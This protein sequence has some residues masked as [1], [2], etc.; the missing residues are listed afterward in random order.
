MKKT[1][2]W[3][4][5]AIFM[6]ETYAST[7]VEAYRQD[8]YV[9]AA[10]LFK[11]APK[12]DAIESYYLGR[13]YLYGYGV[14]KSNMLAS[15]YIHTAA[16]EGILPAQL[17]MAKMEL[18][19][20]ND[21]EKALGWFKRAADADDASAQ[22]YC[23]GAY[24]FGVG[25]KANADRARKYYI[26]AARDDN[27]I[28]QRTLAA[29]FL[30]SR[31]MS[32]KKLGLVWLKKAVELRDPEAEMMI[33]QMYLEG[34]M[35]TM[36]QDQ[37]KQYLE[38]AVD[39][40]Y[41]PA[42]VALGRIE[43][44][45]GRMRDAETWYRKAA[46]KGFT[47][48]QLIL[49]SLYAD[50]ENELYSAHDGFLWM[51][52]AGQ[53][54]SVKARHALAV[55]YEKGQGVEAN[56]TVAASWE[57][58]AKIAE[59]AS[60]SSDEQRMAE[61]LTN[62]KATRL[63][64]TAYRLPGILGQWKNTAAL[65]EGIYNQP[66][67][68]NRLTRQDIYRTEFRMLDPKE[69][70][71]N[72]Y[73]DALMMAQGPVVQSRLQFPQ[74]PIHISIDSNSKHKNLLQAERDGY[75]Y[76]QKISVTS[77][78]MDYVS[79]FKQLM[80]QAVLGDG[81]AQF[82]VALMYQ[83][84]IG[85]KKSTE[86]AIKFYLMAAAQDD[87]PAEYQLGLIYFQGWGVTP[88]E[89]TGI[90]FLNDAAFKGNT[91][92]QYALAR[93]YEHGYAVN[94]KEIIP[95]DHE[96]AVAMYQLSAANH[97]GMAEY[98]LAEIMVRE[99][100]VDLSDAG[101][102]DRR[103]VIKRLYEDS[104]EAGVEAA[105]LPLAFYDATDPDESKQAQAFEEAQRVAKQGSFDGA[106]LLGL[107]YDRGIATG[108]SHERAIHWYEQSAANPLSSFILGTYAAEGTG[109]RKNLEKASNYL[110]FSANKGFAPANFNLAVLKHDQG[111]TFLPYLEKSVAQGLNRAGLT[112]ADYLVSSSKSDQQLKEAHDLYER[113][114]TQGDPTAQV[115]LGYLYEQGIGVHQDY[116][117]AQSWYTRAAEQAQSRGQFLLGRLY[118][119]GWIGKNPDM[120]LAKKWYGEAGSK[121]APAAV[122]YGFI[123]ETVN[124]DYMHAFN[125]YQKAADLRDPIAYFNLGLIYEN[126]KGQAI[127]WQKAEDNYLLAAEQG[128]VKAMVSLGKL[129]LREQKTQDALLWL[130]KAERKQDADASYLLGLMS[131]RGMTQQPMT[132]AIEYYQEAAKQ[133]QAKA[134]LALARIYQ[135][136]T[137]VSKNLQQ[138]ADYYSQL[139]QQDY[140]E[141]QYQLAKFCINGQISNCT[142]QEG[143]AW[144]AK[145][146]RNG[147]KEAAQLLRLY[148][149]NS[150][151]DV[152]Y[153]ESVTLSKRKVRRNVVDL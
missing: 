129:Y 15:K 131:E 105:K 149:A 62:G 9:K 151:D 114:A 96:Q 110:Q 98:R 150:Q 43:Q 47:P 67:K 11:A 103:K 93:I 58:K 128:V 91:Y 14:L 118:Q 25:T 13:M 99:K 65:R 1:I 126:G 92:A 123:E 30:E 71:I 45:N 26:D 33:A 111:E 116:Q 94:G 134:M 138:A 95:K 87:S 51:L 132:G 52:K 141:A 124:D 41:F 18:F 39:Q 73:Y 48:A 86:E 61:W 40:G 89:L 144:L 19:Q 147:C 12:L 22:F 44:M 38:D 10:A 6:Q 85:V 108:I 143:K 100:P 122:A 112:L 32:N 46:E 137:G 97:Y 75:D 117:K 59:A 127:D 104:A 133:G 5:L 42:M 54:G 80:N 31:Q 60:T 16:E 135:R 37:A 140:P 57:K 7:G 17:L 8:D 24:L 34:N 28:A 81:T 63:A 153:I 77:Q 3:C 78:Q 119:Y 36:D 29:H 49:A 56:P 115:K 50:P 125:E 136:G 4:C 68:I 53:S 130:H 120:N 82:D 83:Q 88:D 142:A 69:I 148:T 27:G 76:L 90:D 64:D 21:A 70:P 66:P 152:S 20:N 145:S 35:V 107:L 139:A 109:L 2:L 72:Q 146:E 113:F 23:A 101:L 106:F 84:G 74:Y 55:M 79:V 121:Y 102:E